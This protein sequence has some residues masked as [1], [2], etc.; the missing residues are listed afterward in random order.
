MLEGILRG[1]TDVDVRLDENKRLWQCSKKTYDGFTK[2]RSDE[3]SVW[4]G[5]HGNRT[6]ATC[7]SIE[8][9]IL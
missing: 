8:F 5:M 9:V 4:N 7:Q 1:S 3:Y 2:L 6:K